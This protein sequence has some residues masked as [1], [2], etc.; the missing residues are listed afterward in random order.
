MLLTNVK[1]LTFVTVG[2][3]VPKYMLQREKKGVGVEPLARYNNQGI[4]MHSHDSHQGNT[5]L[6]HV[7]SKVLLNA[8][9]LNPRQCVVVDEI[10]FVRR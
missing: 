8:S 10:R 3:K 1:P 2:T 7:D 5:S 4:V 6:R 9:N